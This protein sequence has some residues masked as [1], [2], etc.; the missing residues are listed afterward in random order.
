MRGS[1]ID[2]WTVRNGAGKGFHINVLLKFFSSL[3]MKS[4]QIRFPLGIA[5][6]VCLMGTIEVG[7][8]P[9]SVDYLFPS[10]AQV[11]ST[12]SVKVGGKFPLWP[13]SVWSSSPDL[14]GAAEEGK[15]EITIEVS[16]NAPAGPHLIR[17]YNAEGAST[18]KSFVVGRFSEIV[19]KEPNDDA[20]KAQHLSE[21]PLTINGRLEK[22]GDADSFSFKLEAGRWLIASVDAYSLDSPVDP[23]LHLMDSTGTKLAFNHD[24]RSLDPFLAFRAEVSGT[25][26]LQIS[27]FAQPPKADIRL[28]GGSSCV[29]RLTVTDG[30][31]ANYA[32]PAGIRRG[33]VIP[34]HVAGW[35]F[36]TKSQSIVC[37][38][39]GTDCEP[40]T[41]QLMLSVPIA[42]NLLR[43]DVGDL[44]EIRELEPNDES[45]LSQPI[46]LPCIVNGRISTP[47]DQD[48][49]SFDAKKGERIR[50][51]IKSHNLGFPLDAVI[52]VTDVNGTE[53]V[54]SD[55][56]GKIPDPDLNWKVP[57]DGRFTVVIEDLLGRGQSDYVYRLEV[58]HPTAD[59][60]A[61]VL[62]DAVRVEPGKTAE[63]KVNVSRLNGFDGSLVVVLD[64]LPEGISATAPNVPS[65]GGE[66]T[67]A[68]L[69]DEQAEPANDSIRVL[70]VAANPRRPEVRVVAANLKG[71]VAAAGQLL[72]NQCKS[73]W[74]TVLPKP[75]EVKGEKEQD[76]DKKPVPDS[77]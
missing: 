43:I 18:L 11:G 59:F 9:P 27:A 40:E 12:V 34:V 31:V 6:A 46:E 57:E 19:E 72:V 37:R 16:T 42:Q 26:V 39:D 49:Y 41:D 15:G 68:I 55:D 20:L 38:A 77:S 14:K 54:R 60:N 47:G 48:R 61:K 35:N 30:P 4:L 56:S 50:I 29:Y 13:V 67:V 32:F 8:E 1:R 76:S 44:P 36:S 51:R 62:A 53:L 21:L 63:L 75:P 58:D 23:L 22:R 28:T 2:V 74:L 52:L 70:V 66:V 73:I 45:A 10:G 64:G 33:T 7:A 5:F 69:A 25:Y 24:G 3:I 71:K 65:K 17:L